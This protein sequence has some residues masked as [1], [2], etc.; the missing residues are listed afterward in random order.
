M[1]HRRG[2][3]LLPCPAPEFYEW[4]LIALLLELFSYA[5]KEESK[6][7]DLS[8]SQARATPQSF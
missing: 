3:A 5:L 4:C 2:L 8:F 7:V 1:K 6:L